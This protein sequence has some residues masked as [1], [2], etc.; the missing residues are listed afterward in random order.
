M[1]GDDI[2]NN[3]YANR[4]KLQEH[5]FPFTLII[6][7]LNFHPALDYIM[8]KPVERTPIE[9]GGST[10]ILKVLHVVLVYSCICMDDCTSLLTC[11]LN[12]GVGA[13]ILNNTLGAAFGT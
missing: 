13:I 10:M 3:L 4:I 6:L 7:L 12:S 2:R 11:P 1:V 9:F 8:C 5:C